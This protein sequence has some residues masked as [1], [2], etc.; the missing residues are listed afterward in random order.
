MSR[1]RLIQAVSEMLP[2]GNGG[3]LVHYGDP[4]G[5]D[6][7]L[8]AVVAESV[9]LGW[10]LGEIDLLVLGAEKCQSLIRAFDPIVVEPLQNGRFVAGSSRLWEELRSSLLSVKPS[11]YSVDHLFRRAVD[12]T[13]EASRWLNRYTASGAL[14]DAQSA[15][16]NLSFACS[17]VLIAR[18]IVAN[19]QVVT[20]DEVSFSAL[21]KKD[22]FLWCI[23][24]ALSLIK[25]GIEL[26][27]EYLWGLLS[28]WNTYILQPSV[29]D[30]GL[31]QSL[32]PPKS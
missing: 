14:R 28:A 20:L 26:P 13:Q 16:L 11:D 19:D 3:V 23:R 24:D 5:S 15:L 1:S 30:G 10:V 12:D 8:L 4:R 32:V 17:S 29:F 22:P 21:L 6:I 9:E 25:Q 31:P 7:D 18:T 27:N 2:L